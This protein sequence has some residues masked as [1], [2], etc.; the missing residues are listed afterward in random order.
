MNENIKRL[1]EK[2]MEY[3]AEQ[4]GPQRQGEKVWNP[5]TYDQKFAELIVQECAKVACTHMEINEGIDYN[6]GDVIKK[7]FGVEHVV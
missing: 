6:V 5:Y 1:A 3:A 2:A 4:Y 7:H